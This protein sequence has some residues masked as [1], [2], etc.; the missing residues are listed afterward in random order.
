M[1]YYMS[2][3]AYIEAVGIQKGQQNRPGFD[4][5]VLRY[6]G[7]G[8]RLCVEPNAV[9]PLRPQPFHHR[10]VQAASIALPPM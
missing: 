3:D 5:P 7:S 8:T 10:V 2:N 6:S 9:V 4:R 1:R